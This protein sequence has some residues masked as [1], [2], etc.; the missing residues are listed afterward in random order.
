MAAW[1]HD[2]RCP[3]CW[4]HRPGILVPEACAEGWDRFPRSQRRALDEALMETRRPDS[5]RLAPGP[6]AFCRRTKVPNVVQSHKAAFRLLVPNVEQ[7]YK[8]ALRLFVPTFVSKFDL[9]IG[10]ACGS[11]GAVFAKQNN[12]WPNRSFRSKI[13]SSNH[14]LAAGKTEILFRK[15]KVFLCLGKAAGWMFVKKEVLRPLPDPTISDPTRSSI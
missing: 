8:A 2:P 6:S 4:Q 14:P 1:W 3:L 7:S 10:A 13:V 5:S 12:F 15:V 11:K 9:A